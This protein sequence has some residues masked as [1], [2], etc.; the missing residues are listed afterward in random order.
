MGEGLYLIGEPV[1]D[2]R[3]YIAEGLATGWAVG[4]ADHN[5]CVAVT[6]GISRFV[7]VARALC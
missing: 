7:T 1:A 6:A 5:A 3:L 2:S 4:R